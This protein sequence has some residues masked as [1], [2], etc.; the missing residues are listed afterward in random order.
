MIYDWPASD[1]L[2]SL[3]QVTADWSNQEGPPVVRGLAQQQALRLPDTEAQPGRT[4]AFSA[5]GTAWIYSS[6]VEEA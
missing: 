1:R 2:D 6:S 4:Q 3:V 5:H